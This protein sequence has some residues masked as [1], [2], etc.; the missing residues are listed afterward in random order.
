MTRRRLLLA[1]VRGV[2][3]RAAARF[4]KLRKLFFNRND[5]RISSFLAVLVARGASRD[6][7]VGREPAQRAGSGDIDVT[8]R[9]LHH[10]FALAA[11]VAEHR[12][13]TRRR[14][15]ANKRGSRLMAAGAVVAGRFLTFPMTSE[16]GVMRIRH[17]LEVSI[18]RR[19]ACS[20]GNQRNRFPTVIRLVTD[21]T[22]VVI[23]FRLVV[24]GP[25]GSSDKARFVFRRTEASQRRDHVLMFVVRKLDRKLPF[26]FWFCRLISR[27][28]LAKSEARIFARRG[29]HVTD[30]TD[31]RA[32]A[33]KS[34]SR[35]ELLTM[36]A[37][38]GV[39]IGKVCGVGKIS[40]RRPLGWQL[41][42]GVAREALVFLG[43]VQKR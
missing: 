33:G 20:R 24:D 13:L 25:E 32:R 2:A 15:D 39:V 19:I 8:R 6:R 16:A 23:D 5:L 18:G 7:N 26:I 43:R 4:L 35:E 14:I 42:T 41:V 9:A 30:G 3:I 22:V 21:R 37:N 10:V 34:L 40:L 11:F 27:I 12:G 1:D 29:A 31:R 17:R 38:A 28:R 36:A